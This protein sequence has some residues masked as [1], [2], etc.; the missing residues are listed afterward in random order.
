VTRSDAIDWCKDNLHYWPK[1]T[2]FPHPEGW[3][4]VMCQRP[5]QLPVFKLVNA[6]GIEIFNKDAG[7]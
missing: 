2:K 6:A 5:Y 3:R 4:W 7:F 1:T